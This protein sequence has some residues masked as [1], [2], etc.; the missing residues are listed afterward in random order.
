MS[1]VTHTLVRILEALASFKREATLLEV[2]DKLGVKKVQVKTAIK[3]SPLVR[4][5][6]VEPHGNKKAEVYLSP[7]DAGVSFLLKYRVQ[8]RRLFRKQR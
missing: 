6:V 4:V 2:A 1:G 5:A 7:T 3:G 8:R